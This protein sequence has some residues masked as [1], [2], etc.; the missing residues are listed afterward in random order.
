MH[1]AIKK[2]ELDLGG[3]I[4]SLT[5]EQAK[6][7]KDALDELFGKEVIREIIRDR[8]FVPVPYIEPYRPY[9]L[10]RYDWQPE[11]W[12]TSKDTVDG[13]CSDSGTLRLTG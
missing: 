7:L 3:K 2:I 5:P 1:K 10:Y 13:Y 6:N 8:D 11:Y 9:R 12:Y 4:I